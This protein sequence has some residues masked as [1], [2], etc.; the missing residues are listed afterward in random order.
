MVIV[1]GRLQAFD[2]AAKLRQQNGYFGRVRPCDWDSLTSVIGVER[3]EVLSVLRA[4][5][6]ALWHHDWSRDARP[7]LR[8]V[9][10]RL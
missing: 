3:A 4:L 6:F 7:G 5:H 10:L 1:D 8:R 9:A 2:T